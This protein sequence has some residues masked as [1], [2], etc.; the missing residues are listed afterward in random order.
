MHKVIGLLSVLLV[1]LSAVSARADIRDLDILSSHMPVLG[2]INEAKDNCWT[3]ESAVKNAAELSLRRAYDEVH[4]YRKDLFSSLNKP[5]YFLNIN[6]HTAR[7]ESGLCFG[8]YEVNAYIILEALEDLRVVSLFKRGGIAISPQD[9]NDSIRS[10]VQ[11]TLDELALEVLRY[12][13]KQN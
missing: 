11:E 13:S 4:F 6:V 1:A 2:T 5:F 7:T 8:N 9:L 12:R 3:N 10:Y